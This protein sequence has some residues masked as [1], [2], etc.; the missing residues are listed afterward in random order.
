MYAHVMY[1]HVFLTNSFFLFSRKA[2]MKKLLVKG[3]TEELL[4]AKENT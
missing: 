2:S 3:N 4:F 1:A